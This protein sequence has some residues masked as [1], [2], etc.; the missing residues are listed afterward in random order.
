VEIVV[1]IQLKN[2]VDDEYGRLVAAWHAAESRRDR[3]ADDALRDAS[4]GLIRAVAAVVIE[5]GT[6][7]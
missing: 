6:T 7:H 2:H 1:D 3:Q 5:L 4:D